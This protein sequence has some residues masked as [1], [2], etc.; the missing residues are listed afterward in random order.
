MAKKQVK[1]EQ[2]CADKNCPVHGGVKPRGRSFTGTVASD[3]MSKTVV[4]SWVRRTYNRKYERYENRISK[5]NAHNPECMSA[6][7]GDLVRISETRPLSKTKHFVI[8]QM[9]GK[10][11]AKESLKAEAIEEAEQVDNKEKEE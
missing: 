6:K 1:Q 9:V 7:K 3:R 2:K 10:L 11:T 5:L 4:V 8:T